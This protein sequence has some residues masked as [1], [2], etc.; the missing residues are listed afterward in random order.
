LTPGC[1]FAYSIFTKLVMVVFL[2]EPP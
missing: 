2:W 1:S